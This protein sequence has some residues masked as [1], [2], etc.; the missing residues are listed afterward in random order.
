MVHYW[1]TN[2]KMCTEWISKEVCIDWAST[3]QLKWN[4]ISHTNHTRF[5][6]WMNQHVMA[7]TWVR[8]CPKQE[9]IDNSRDLMHPQADPENAIKPTSL[10][11]KKTVL[12]HSNYHWV[13]TLCILVHHTPAQRTHWYFSGFWTGHQL[14]VLILFQSLSILFHYLIQPISLAFCGHLGPHQL[15]A[16][17][18][19]ISVIYITCVSFG[20]GLAFGGDTYFSQVGA[21]R[22]VHSVSQNW[23]L[24]SKHISYFSAFFTRL[25]KSSTKM[26]DWLVCM[27]GCSLNSFTQ[28]KL[29][30]V[31][32]V[33]KW[34]PTLDAQLV[35]LFS[36]IRECK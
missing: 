3:K 19:A 21:H 27:Y 13:E 17:A 25:W 8:Q 31:R 1:S 23:Y 36:D 32:S 7:E 5:L 18:M 10:L 22:L 24:L 14:S 2:H 16:V 12:A 11:K 9:S 15:A 20:R 6:R 34:R 35:S 28:T 30:P 26:C 33:K 4:I 29:H